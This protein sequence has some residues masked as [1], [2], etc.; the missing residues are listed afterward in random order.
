MPTAKKNYDKPDLREKIK[1][2]VTA[3]DKGGRPGQWSARKAQLVAHE[4][5][6]AGGG[7][8]GPPAGNQKHLRQWTDEQWQTADGKPA[9]RGKTTHRYLP[10][11]AWDQL[12]PAQQAATDQK[13]VAGGR[14]GQQFV[15]NT[16]AA[17][18]SRRRA[19]AGK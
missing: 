13:K 2:R 5:E 18:R 10:K 19:T 9:I 8:L 17:K 1:A 3:G 16:P 14:R 12:T 15:A 7:Y 4:Y 11:K 6:A